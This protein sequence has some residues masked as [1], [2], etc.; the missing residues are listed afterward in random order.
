M[1]PPKKP[2]ARK[3]NK[4]WAAIKAAGLAISIVK[5]T[6]ESFALF[7]H[8]P[9][10]MLSKEDVQEG[11]FTMYPPFGAPIPAADEDSNFKLYKETQNAAKGSKLDLAMLRA[12]DDLPESLRTIIHERAALESLIHAAKKSATRPQKFL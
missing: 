8:I 12:I 2:R 3:I 10:N 6:P 7:I 4:N 1:T 11:N 9:L 5:W